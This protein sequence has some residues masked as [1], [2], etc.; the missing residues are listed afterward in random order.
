MT[1]EERLA[2]A[3]EIAAQTKPRFVA[4]NSREEMRQERFA[5][6][7][8]LNEALKRN[9]QSDSDEILFKILASV[10]AWVALILIVAAVIELHYGVA[11]TRMVSVVTILLLIP[12]L[13][14]IWKR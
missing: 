11:Q 10:I 7:K 14:W 2:L 5:K 4:D 13:Y 3:R 9:S 8:R 1:L 12:C 6:A